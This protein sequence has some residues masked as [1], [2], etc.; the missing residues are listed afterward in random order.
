MVLT[1]H[2]EGGSLLQNQKLQSLELYGY[3]ISRSAKWKSEMSCLHDLVDSQ[4]SMAVPEFPEDP[5]GPHDILGIIHDGMGP[6][7]DAAWRSPVLLEQTLTCALK[8][9][10]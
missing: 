10:Q 7:D 6:C 3:D 8:G 1:W 9:A 2:R 5:Y 4:A